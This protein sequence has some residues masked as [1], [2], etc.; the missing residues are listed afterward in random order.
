MRAM[1]Y[2]LA[3]LMVGCFALTGSV[4]T[5]TAKG[6][7]QPPS[8]KITID[9]C[10]KKKPPVVFDHPKHAKMIKEQKQDCQAC[11]HLVANKA[12]S[13]DLC[14]DCHMKPQ[15]KLG[16]C[17]D[18][19]QKKNPFHVRCVGCHKKMKAEGKKPPTACNGCH[20]KG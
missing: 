17:Q 2:L 9:G 14:S 18:M 10:K 12:P 3:I 11:H 1:R 5:A 4:L 16:T 13:K 7:K 8:K 6:K 15:G 19:S 20:A